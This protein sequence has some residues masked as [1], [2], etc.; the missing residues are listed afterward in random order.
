MRFTNEEK[1]HMILALGAADGNKRKAAQIYQEWHPGDRVSPN[2][3]L[4][5]YNTLRQTGTFRKKRRQNETVNE[6]Q[7][8]DVLAFMAANP[9]AS[10]RDVSGQVTASKSTVWRILSKANMHPYHVQLHQRLE[11][12]D[13]Q[14]RLEFANWILIKCDEDKD[15]LSNVLWTDEA[16]FCRNGHVN[17]HNAHYWSATNPHWLLQSRHQYQW[18]FSVWCGIFDGRIIGP[19]FFDKTLT[20]NLYVSEILEGQV[21]EFICSIPLAQLRRIWFQH[22]GAPAHSSSRSRDWLRAAFKE[23]W[24]GRH[25]P[26]PWPPRSPDMTPLDFFLWGYI[27]DRVYARETTTPDALKL[28]ITQV[29]RE[30]PESVIR[31]ATANVV[32]RCQCC[33]ASSGDLFEHIL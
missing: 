18:S 21:D 14:S 10:V 24:I 13:L 25:G 19:V 29:C 16:N 26:V 6:D 1:A 2:T 22:D 20:T 33:V 8:A 23:Q 11:P 12:R 31:R 7:E 28:K 4:N 30:I 32:N 17:L 3:V 9:H 5:V 27:K 15:F